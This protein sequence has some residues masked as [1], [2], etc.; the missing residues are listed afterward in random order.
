MKSQNDDNDA[1]GNYVPSGVALIALGALAV[2]AAFILTILLRL[3]L[4][5]IDSRTMGF[6]GLGFIAVGSFM[7]RHG[8]SLNH[9]S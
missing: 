2:V 3:E 9:L 4:R 7:V 1:G 5:F 6:I 8:K